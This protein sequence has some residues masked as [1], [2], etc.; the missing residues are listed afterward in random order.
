MYMTTEFDFDIFVI[1]IFFIIMIFYPLV[2]MIHLPLHS[3]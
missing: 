1:M 3:I 2:Y